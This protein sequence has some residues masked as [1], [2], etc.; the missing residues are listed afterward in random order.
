VVELALLKMA[1]PDT[2]HDVAALTSRLDRLEERTRRARPDEKPAVPEATVSRP[3]GVAAGEAA[4]RSQ[5][6]ASGVER[7]EE[8]EGER[9]D[10]EPAGEPA[11]PR[12]PTDADVATVVEKWPVV[13]ARVRD[14]AGPRRFALFREARP[15]AMEGSTLV[16]VVPGPFHRDQLTED[17]VLTAVVRT[18]LSDVLGG[19]V[20]VRYEAGD[21]GATT[22]PPPSETPARAPDEADLVESDEGAIDPTALV[23]DMLGGE[24]VSD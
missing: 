14:E 2:A 18:V 21:D 10:P 4:P 5:R 9:G 8:D 1:R 13:V 24:V 17:D 12:A 19:G 6:A 11:A 16:L 15:H 23:V 3:A 22:G 20:D 7:R